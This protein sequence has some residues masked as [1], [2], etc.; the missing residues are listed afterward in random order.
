M[1]VTYRIQHNMPAVMRAVEQDAQQ[2]KFATVVAM[3]K[4][5]AWAET[6]VRRDMRK[7]FDRPTAFFLRSLRSVRASWRAPK[8]EAVL[9]FK[10]SEADASD[11][12]S[13]GEAMVVPHIHGGTRKRKPMEQ[14]LIRAGLMPATYYSVPGAGADLDGHGNMSRGQVTQLLNVLG[15]YR[16]AGYNKAN[17]KTVE[18]LKKGNAKKG[19]YG[20]EYWVNPVAGRRAQH[21]PPGVYKRFQTAFGTSLKPIL[22]F[23]SRANYRRRF[24]FFGI[25]EKSFTKHFPGE[26]DRAFEQALRTAR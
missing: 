3:N 7:T 13:G 15:T 16:E 12:Q 17:A 25:A 23:V 1:T 19:I 4:A 14:R 8:P 9:W 11:V 24:D 18:R 26:F 22:I 21:L 10:G 5:L 20:F 6:D 2:A